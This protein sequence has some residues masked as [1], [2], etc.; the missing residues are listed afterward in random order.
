MGIDSMTSK[1]LSGINIRHLIADNVTELK[2]D[3][4]RKYPSSYSSN[5]MAK[6]IDINLRWGTSTT[7]M[8]ATAARTWTTPESWDEIRRAGQVEPV[9]RW[10]SHR[11][12]G[13]WVRGL[14]SAEHAH[15]WLRQAYQ[16]NNGYW[17]HWFTISQQCYSLQVRELSAVMRPA[18]GDSCSH[19]AHNYLIARNYPAPSGKT[20]F[21][22]QPS[23]QGAIKQAHQVVGT[24]SF[25]QS[26][27]WQ[28]QQLLGSDWARI[29]AR[30]DYSQRRSWNSL[31]S[32]IHALCAVHYGNL[33]WSAISLGKHPATTGN[34]R[35]WWKSCV[36]N[37]QEVPRQAFEIDSSDQSALDQIF[38]QRYPHHYGPNLAMLQ[39]EPSRR[40]APR[41]W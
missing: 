8:L 11:T 7:L 37:S 10:I 6:Q 2:C 20:P 19:H 17:P 34:W 29:A 16:D 40:V 26:N 31:P 18:E 13:R 21:C 28:K 3:N 25:R 33:G 27:K 30:F 14:R 1:Y 23:P 39:F 15:G 38:G 32:W 4:H 9:S 24:I 41:P 35:R 36:N 5:T 22:S 12:A